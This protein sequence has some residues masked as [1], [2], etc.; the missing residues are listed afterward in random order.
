M[1]LF[2]SFLVGVR[3]AHPNL[4]GLFAAVKSGRNRENIRKHV[5]T[6]REAFRELDP[7]F[8]AIENVPMRGFR[9]NRAGGKA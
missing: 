7:Q 8:D 5:S 9:W 3:Y 6:L 1:G 4:C 2:R